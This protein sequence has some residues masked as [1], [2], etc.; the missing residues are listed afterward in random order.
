[1]LLN[2]PWVHAQADLLFKRLQREA[3]DDPSARIQRL[4][5]I[6]YQRSATNEEE[7]ICLKFL[8]SQPT[9]EKEANIPQD[10]LPYK[11]GAW[12]SLCRAILNSSEA[13]Y[14]D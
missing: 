12:Q 2:D 3:G 1:M 5:R 13:I 7:R 14:I 6:A 4:W 10:D 8:S 11:I 9:R